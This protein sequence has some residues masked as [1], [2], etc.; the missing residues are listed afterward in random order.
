MRYHR[1]EVV[2]SAPEVSETTPESDATQLA[3]LAR[4]ELANM[5]TSDLPVS[6][7]GSVQ[8]CR[9]GNDTTSSG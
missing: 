9:C 7:S 2:E 5:E 1:R 6:E 3:A 4:E 8:G